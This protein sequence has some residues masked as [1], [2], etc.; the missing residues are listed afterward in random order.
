MLETACQHLREDIEGEIVATDGNAEGQTEE[1]IEISR[2][3]LTLVRKDLS[4]LSLQ[5]KS[6]SGLPVYGPT[7]SDGK[8]KYKGTHFVRYEDSFIRKS[9]ALYLLQENIQLSNDRLLRV[10]EEQPDH[11]YSGSSVGTQNP[12]HVISGDLCLFKRIDCEKILV[13]R[14]LQFSYYKEKT[15]KQQAYSSPYVDMTKASYKTIGVFASWYAL[16]EDSRSENSL[17]F[18]DVNYAF[19]AGYCGMENYIGTI[20]GHIN[21]VKESSFSI[22]ADKISSLLPNW[23][24]SLSIDT[25]FV[26]MFT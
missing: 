14:I 4:N 18:K 21:N 9:T 12:C 15:K 20:T 8:R 23:M 1:E 7:T 11:L 22:P 3:E 16:D 13:G 5:K 26:Q 2:E 17:I 25:E 10:R 19:R 24:E 6:T